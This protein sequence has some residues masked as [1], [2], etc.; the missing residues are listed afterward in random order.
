MAEIIAQNSRWNEAVRRQRVRLRI[1]LALVI[2]AVVVLYAATVTPGHAVVADDFAAY[3]MHAAN[4]VEGRPYS[5]IHYV[6]NPAAVGFAPAHGYPPVYP[7]ILAPVYKIWG[8]N[9]RAMKI[10]T[11]LCFGIFMG[12]FSLLFEDALPSWAVSASLLIMGLNVAFWEQRDYVLSEF[13]YLMF[14]FCALLAAQ[15]IYKNLDPRTWRFGAA[16]LLSLLLYATYGTR[17]IGIVLLPALVLADLW[18][19]R[20]PSRL[21][22]V[23]VVVTLGLILLQNMLLVSPRAYMNVVKWSAEST[24]QRVMFYVKTLSY[25]WRNGVSKAAQIVFALLFTALAGMG[26]CKAFWTRRSI[27]QFYLLGYLAVLIAWPTEIGMRGLLPVLPLYFAF[28]LQAFAS[29]TGRLTHANR[30]ACLVFLFAFIGGTYVCAFRWNARQEHVLD[31]RD[32]EVQQVFTYVKENAKPT[33]LIVFQKPRTLALFTERNTTMLAPAEPPA[34]SRQFL[35][36][37]K[38]KFLIQ[39]QSMGYPIKELIANG[40]LSPTP[41]FDNGAFQVYRI[42]TAG[43][44]DGPITIE[45]SLTQLGPAARSR[46]PLGVQQVSHQRRD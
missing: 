14:S 32:P 3:V 2:F 10:M 25:V 35:A 9:L 43:D 7:L 31:V 23:V 24:G 36:T 6:P 19:F 27:V 39:N 41:I 4:L 38:A 33:D 29:V 20:R 44:D 42:E 16:L 45:Q 22:I 28:G 11:V 34:Q 37:T 15:K 30:A 26:F 21:L 1:G 8:L 40:S 46:R 17:T 12:V 18:K 5:D 13:P